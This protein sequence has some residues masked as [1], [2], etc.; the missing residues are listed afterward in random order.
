M[1]RVPRFRIPAM[2][3]L[4][5]QLRFA[6]HETRVR[7]MVA[8][9]RLIDDVE[10][11]RNY[12]HDFVTY[13][14]TGYRP[15]VNEPVTIVGDALLGDLATLIQH[16]SDGLELAWD[17]AGRRALP[18]DEVAR[19]LNVSTKTIQ[20]YRRRGLVCHYVIDRQGVSQLV[21]FDDALER[22]AAR[23]R[24]G[25]DRASGFTRMAD[26][27]TGDV[28]AA[29]RRLREEQG[30]SL[31]EA[32][33]RIGRDLGRAHETI[34]SVLRRHDETAETPI[35]GEHGPLTARDDRLI[36]R[37][38]R[39]G[40][41]ERTLAARFGKT[42]ATIR[43]GRNRAR[44]ARLRGLAID[45]IHL[46]TFDLPDADGVILGAP[47]VTRDL[48]AVLPTH[49]ALA[50][51]EA[52]HAAP[53]PSDDD[54]SA[55]A[56]GYNL[57]K[58][59]AGSAIGALSTSPRGGDLDR[60]ERDLRWAT[61][62]VRRLVVLGLPTAIRRIEQNLHRAL[63]SQP[64]ESIVRLV[65]RGREVVGRAVEAFDPSRGQYLE[66]IVAYAMDRALAAPG[67]G[68][69]GG[70]AAARHGPGGVR[71]DG[72]LDGLTPWEPLLE[73]PRALAG[74]LDRL[75]PREAEALAAHYGLGPTP[76]RT[77]A[78]VADG[79]GLTVRRARTLIR[80]AETSLRRAR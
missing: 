1:P 61:R 12:P 42:A 3:E 23:H 55:L 27:A 18:I 29:A 19:R 28:V 59:R 6:P 60:I 56:A 24:E 57:L 4:Y 48:D 36:L 10:P 67:A 26:A 49:D 8:A 80:R 40:I 34:R 53:G 15:D 44:A 79:L 47:A 46:P 16:L 66:G 20:R 63:A 39:R 50:L 52:A 22:F 33:R 32:A 45:A 9:E 74:R 58:R 35:F 72:L 13:R 65:D 68:D 69:R 5:R 17:H 7:E 14:I 21:C 43:R 75:P 38:W 78:E 70:R 73:M 64:A 2:A 31:N 41:G 71:L 51:I 37:A 62:L 25:L 54:V 77:P 11:D 30:L 76:P